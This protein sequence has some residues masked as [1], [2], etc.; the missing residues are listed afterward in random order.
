VGNARPGTAADWTKDRIDAL[1]TAEV[2]QL[3]VNAERLHEPEITTLCD[4]ILTAR[5]KKTRT[6]ARTT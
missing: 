4:Q 6:K 1:T 3:R 2:K 5:R